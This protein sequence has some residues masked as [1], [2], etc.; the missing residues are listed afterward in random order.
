MCGE[1]GTHLL[2]DGLD[3][4]HDVVAAVAAEEVEQG[5]DDRVRHL[6]VARGAAV[7]GLDEQRLVLVAVVQIRLLENEE[8]G[9]G[10][11]GKAVRYQR[12]AW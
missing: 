1:L 10:M 6:R 7:D 8:E 4:E 3:A 5:E 2:D 12:K 11:S 9:A